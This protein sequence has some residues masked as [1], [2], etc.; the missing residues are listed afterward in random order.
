MDTDFL[1]NEMLGYNTIINFVWYITVEWSIYH[2][3]DKQYSIPVNNEQHVL[4]NNSLTHN[5]RGKH[6][7]NYEEYEGSVK[8]FSEMNFFE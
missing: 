4:I 3:N 7:N 2:I 6:S 8:V 5:T 1:V